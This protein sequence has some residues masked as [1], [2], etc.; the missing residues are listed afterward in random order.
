MIVK[1]ILQ[2]KGNTPI[3]T[4]DPT[5]SVAEAARILSEKRIGALIAVDQGG[6]IVGIFSE[7]DAVRGMALHGEALKDR[8]VSDLMTKDVQ[9]CSENDDIDQL[10]RVMT[11]RR[12][13]HLPVVSDGALVGIVTI[14]DVVKS[15]LDEVEMEVD[16]LRQYIVAGH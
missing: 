6:E 9:V 15:K 3:Q 12:I 8:K 5:M 16:N 4:I 11:T 2:Q 13:R 10:M 7:R 14:G 1:S